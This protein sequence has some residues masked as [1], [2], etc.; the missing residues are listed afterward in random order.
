M[1][2]IVLVGASGHA[3]VI[4]DAAQKSGQFEILGLIDTYQPIGEPLFNYKILGRE[5]DLPGLVQEYAIEGSVV[6]IGDNW[7]R[8][9]MV[10]RIKQLVPSL[11]FPTVIHPF[12]AIGRGAVIG[13]GTV[14]LAGA[15]INSDARV[16]DFCIINTNSSLDHDSELGDFS[17]LM[18]NSATGGNVTIGA[19]SCLGL[20]ASVIH[21]VTIGA[22]T[23]IG[24]GATVISNVP[25]H[26]VSVGSPARVTRARQEGEK[27][28]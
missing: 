3:K 6:A 9:Q 23:V 16:G 4:A 26:V 14:L 19:F 18:P 22:H 1:K 21:S 17:A 24:A 25:D 8:Y 7:T 13:A 20:G 15:V 11:E 12:T 10:Q 27:Y 2:R 5:E 28:L